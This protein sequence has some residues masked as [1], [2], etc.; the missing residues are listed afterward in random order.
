M[1]T[2]RKKIGET[3]QDVIRRQ[4]QEK[5]ARMDKAKDEGRVEGQVTNAKGEV[6]R[7]PE[8][9]K[10]FTERARE[11]RD[12]EVR[13]ERAREFRALADPKRAAEVE[14]AVSQIGKEKPQEEQVQKTLKGGEQIIINAEGKRVL[15]MP[16]GRDLPINTLGAP[17]DE[18]NAAVDKGLQTAVQIA[19]APILITAGGA[20]LSTGSIGA[21]AAANTVKSVGLGTKVFGGLFGATAITGAVKLSRTQDKT[22]ATTQITNSITNINDII[23]AVQEGLYAD[24]PMLAVEMFNAELQNI[25]R[26]EKTLYALSRSPFEKVKVF[27]SGAGAGLANVE[28][29]RRIQNQY[30]LRL[31]NALGA[32]I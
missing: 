2:R 16:D 25:A 4:A 30:E 22:E 7:T 5:Q 15:R 20:L 31:Q 27:S 9:Q 1:V 12:E 6:I 24:N 28:A 11:F 14:S 8:Q 26:N 17:T 21:S 3:E 13:P 29:F 32:L 19:A 23:T 18:T 10:E